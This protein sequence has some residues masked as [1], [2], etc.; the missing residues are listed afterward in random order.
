ME[1]YLMIEN[2]NL[3]FYDQ[4]LSL[5]VAFSERLWELVFIQ[6]FYVHLR[7]IFWNL[8]ILKPIT[9]PLNLL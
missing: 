8:Y 9:E 5:R 7:D 3:K 1:K 4:S 2:G 6:V